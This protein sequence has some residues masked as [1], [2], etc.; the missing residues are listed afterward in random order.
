MKDKCP[1]A[2][3]GYYFQNLS[4]ALTAQVA[5]VKNANQAKKLVARCRGKLRKVLINHPTVK[6]ILNLE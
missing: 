6:R 2:F 4:M 1:K 5:G 3:Q